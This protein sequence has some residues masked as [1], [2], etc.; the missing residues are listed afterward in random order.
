M[1]LLNDYSLKT[2]IIAITLISS[3]VNFMIGA[4]AVY[5]VDSIDRKLMLAG[6]IND[7]IDQLYKAQI[8][9]K[10]WAEEAGKFRYNDNTTSLDVETDNRKC[11]FGKWFYSSGRSMLEKH[12]PKTRQDLS[13]I[14][15]LHRN[16]HSSAVEL[17][18]HLRDKKLDAASEFYNT[19]IQVILRE[20]D[21]VINRTIEISE[22]ESYSLRLESESFADKLRVFSILVAII[23]SILILSLGF[24]LGD[25]ITKPI[26]NV[27]SMLKDIAEGEG[28]LTKQINYT[29]RD[30][31]GSMVYWFNDFLKR[32]RTII[33][34]IA[35]NTSILA[36]SSEN[37]SA[38]ST[39]LA[40]NTQEISSQSQ[41]V[42]LSTSMASD[43]V[44]RISSA[45][46]DM[47]S[48]INTVATVIEQMS[49]SINEVAKSC[50]KESSLAIDANEQTDSTQKIME[51][52]EKA[53]KEIGNI[54]EVINDISE[55]TNLLALNAAIEAASAGSSGKGF[56]VVANE[57]KNLAKQTSQATDDIQKRI[58]LMQTNTSEVIGA[59]GQVTQI[60]REINS[61]SQSI[62]SSV[63]EQ[64]ATITEISKNMNEAN[65]FAN[66]IAGNVSE[67]ANS[68][69]EITSNIKGVDSG[70]QQAAEGIGLIK[71]SIDELTG[72]IDQLNKIVNKFK[73]TE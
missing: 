24:M 9:H 17:D 34:Q 5:S 12:I 11:N 66:D 65:L 56:A 61:V 13:K 60:I 6:E 2:K 4:I 51:N 35:D 15:Q 71:N 41:S 20:L 40:S 30:E 44:N 19:T 29:T 46:K 55:Q 50:Q 64:S 33:R 32:L 49:V 43:N 62:V 18:N 67:T 23:S 37:L 16:L 39:Q 36:T 63:E 68:F 69:L 31:I 10:N 3:L 14:E 42:S 59:I 1:N 57:V 47:S 58:E 25:K 22:D 8:D 26:K 53:A 28:D 45:A 72:M 48:S 73:T 52:L 7:E 70:T 27:V 38:A 21:K 54:I